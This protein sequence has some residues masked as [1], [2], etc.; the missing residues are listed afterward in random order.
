MLIGYAR[1]STSDQNLGLQK[2]ALKQVECKQIFE[3]R[4]SGAKGERE[5]LLQA[6]APL[7]EGD[8]LV[9][10]KLDRLGLNWLSFPMWLDKR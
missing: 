2:N 4:K 8:T 7:R 5:G 1:V 9:V 3:D 10:W 6:L